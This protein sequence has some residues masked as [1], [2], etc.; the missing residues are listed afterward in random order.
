MVREGS[1]GERSETTALKFMKQGGFNPGVKDRKSN[2]WA[3]WWIR[4][5]RSDGWRNKW[6][7]NGGTGTKMRLTK[8]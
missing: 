2:G 6:H 5:E 4:R 8:R 1:P 7:G 3:K